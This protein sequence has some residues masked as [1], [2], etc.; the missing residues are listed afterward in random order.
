[1]TGE[2]FDEQAPSLS[3]ARLCCAMGC[4]GSVLLEDEKGSLV[5]VSA[6]DFAEAPGGVNMVVLARCRTA[7]GS[8]SLPGLAL[9]LVAAGIPAVVAM[10]G[11]VSD[12]FSPQLAEHLYRG[13][14]ASEEPEPL[15]VLSAARRDIEAA[16]LASTANGRDTELVEW[17][18]PVL[19]LGALPG[20]HSGWPHAQILP[21]SRHHPA[22]LQLP[23]PDLRRAV[24]GGRGR[25]GTEV[26]LEAPQDITGKAPR[27]RRWPLSRRADSRSVPGPVG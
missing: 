21:V 12:D 6:T 18:T 2:S 15:A 17:A 16:R 23:L 22:P 26:R 24:P 3:R 4:P 1:M 10:A 7:I 19:F 5:Q 25:G 8:E 11:P 27:R 13:L 9:D 20:L 14:A